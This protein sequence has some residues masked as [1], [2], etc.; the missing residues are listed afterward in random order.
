MSEPIVIVGSGFAA[1]QLVKAI[2][3]QDSDTNICVITADDGH[4]YNKPDLSHVFS[5]AQNKN[6]LIVASGDEFAQQQKFT[7]L[8]RSK[9]ESIN[10]QARC[11]VVN[12]EPIHY[13]KLVL[14]TGASAFIPPI[15]GNGVECVRTLNSLEEFAN[16]HDSLNDAQRVMVLGGGL[17]GVEIALDLANA[18]KSVALIEPA[19]TLMANQLPDLIGFKLQQHL[20]I[21]GIDIQTGVIVEQINQLNNKHHVELSNGQLLEMDE[22][23]VCAGLR[24]NTDLA[25][26]AGVSVNKGIVV[27][28]TLQTSVAN[29]Y[30]LGD[31]AELMGEV[32]S[33]LQPILLS[34]NAL[35][36]TLLGTTTKVALPTMMVKVKTPSYPIQLA[37]VTSGHAIAHWQIEAQPQGMVA[38]AYDSGNKPIG[39]VAT[40]QMASQAFTLLRELATA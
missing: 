2:R 16:H 32:R 38:K 21:K 3:R 20:M 17:I 19:S 10:A 30:A 6:D 13:A 4:D 22:V 27:D 37:G 36:K 14:A 40:D 35:A 23:V 7:L 11:V 39:F 25:Q 5:K 33:Y 18:G 1:Y 34:A 9:V 12:G 28:Q 26:S 15:K 24:A 8:S 29:I 31:C